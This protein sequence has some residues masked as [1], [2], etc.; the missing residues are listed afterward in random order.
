MYLAQRRWP[1]LAEAI[2]HLDNG[3]AMPLE[4]AVLRAR[5]CL[6]RKE[7]AAARRLLAETITRY[8][9]EVWPRVI[10]SHCL[11]EEGSDRAGAERALLGILEFDPGN[12]GARHNL[13]VL[14]G[15]S[16]GVIAAVRS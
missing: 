4:A 14:R 11:L 8:P 5:A 6:A 10:L 2:G 3:L 16:P 15:R 9:R 1:E 12:A 13:H 7:F